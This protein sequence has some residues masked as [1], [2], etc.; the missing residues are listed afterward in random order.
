MSIELRQQMSAESLIAIQ[1]LIDAEVERLDR[2]RLEVA[3][4]SRDKSTFD[5]IEKHRTE[6]TQA[7][8]QLGALFID[9]FP[10]GRLENDQ[11]GKTGIVIESETLGL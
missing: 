8:Q 6:L 3:G 9:Q 5:N 11:K 7:R 1:R 4:Y 2:F 10:Q